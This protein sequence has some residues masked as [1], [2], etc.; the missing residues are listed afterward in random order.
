MDYT[1]FGTMLGQHQKP[2]ESFTTH[3][4]ITSALQNYLPLSGGELTGNLNM[5]NNKIFS[6]ADPTGE[7]QAAN[8]QYVDS[9]INSLAN[10]AKTTFLEVDGSNKLTRPLDAGN[11]R[12]V[13]VGA[14][15]EDND[16]TTKSYVDSKAAF[17]G[18]M[19]G[20][21]I[22]NMRTPNQDNDAATKKYVDDSQPARSLSVHEGDTNTEHKF[23]RNIVFKHS[24]VAD[25]GRKTVEIT[26]KV[27]VGGFL[28]SEICLNP[29]LSADFKDDCVYVSSGLPE[30]ALFYKF[31]G[32]SHLVYD[33]S[34][35]N[36][37]EG[38]NSFEIRNGY[39]LHITD[40]VV[41]IR[42]QNSYITGPDN[43]GWTLIQEL[44]LHQQFYPALELYNKYNPP[45]QILMIQIP[46]IFHLS[47]NFPDFTAL[48]G[49]QPYHN[50][51]H[52]YYIDSPVR[53]ERNPN[54]I[55][56]EGTKLTFTK[57]FNQD[58]T[59]LLKYAVVEVLVE[60]SNF[61][62]EMYR[63]NSNTNP[64]KPPGNGWGLVGHINTS[65]DPY[66]FQ[67]PF[68]SKNVAIVVKA[69][70]AITNVIIKAKDSVVFK[71][72]KEFSIFPGFD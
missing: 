24:G 51:E 35:K 3:S 64:P 42:G 8:K 56:P 26:P 54:K 43:D 30:A 72:N 34:G 65:Q 44:T 61:S 19:A 7:K 20:K 16:A 28:T 46:D 62:V 23:Q 31:R 27:K 22:I 10:A 14:P 2:V 67:V 71:C 1:K 69:T 33:T 18:D 66:Y 15:T 70:T 38:S 49:S 59:N 52:D 53:I 25:K 57:V 41:F 45:V 39:L 12:M 47:H 13:N 40:N 48:S 21:R 9:M 29:P 60:S 5:A 58:D 50:T 37:L 11:Q 32:K 17:D 4:N 6:L 68:E 36:L 63:W 55:V